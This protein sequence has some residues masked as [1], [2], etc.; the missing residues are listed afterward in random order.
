MKSLRAAMGE[1]TANPQ[2][3]QN[4]EEELREFGIIDGGFQLPKDSPRPER[5]REAFLPAVSLPLPQ[6]NDAEKGILSSILQ[7]PQWSMI[8]VERRI[9]SEHF[10]LPNHQ[11]IFKVL[12]EMH[13]ADE[14]IDLITLTNQ[15]DKQGILDA[16]GGAAY[17]TEL[18]T[19]VPTATNIDYYV[20]IVREKYALRQVI[21]LCS[22][23]Q[24]EAYSP[25]SN[26]L[27]TISY[28]SEEVERVATIISEGREET[29]EHT[30]LHLAALD[31]QNDP[32]AVLGRRWVCRG[33][34]CLWVGQAG[35]GKSSLAM[36]ASLM[37]AQAKSLWGIKNE[38]GKRLKSLF[39]QAENDAGDMA[40]ML[41]GVFAMCEPPEGVSREDFLADLQKYM[42]FH[43]DATHSGQAFARSTA[44]LIAK[45]QPDLVWIDPLLSYV[46]DDISKQ[47][48]A[49]HFLRNTMN[50]IAL[51]TG[52]VWMMLHHTGKPSNDPKSRSNW[53][54]HD[55]SYAA[56]GSSELVNWARAVNVL[57]SLG[58]N[59][60]ELRFAKRGKRAGLLEY[61]AFD[62][63]ED[64]N[65]TRPDFTDIAYL[66]H[67]QRGIFWEQTSIPD[68]V[69]DKQDR[70]KNSGQFQKKDHFNEDVLLSLLAKK[71][72][73]RKTVELSQIAT[74]ETGVSRATFYRVWK[75]L[76]ASGRVIEKQD[77]WHPVETK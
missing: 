41:Q 23:M 9:G 22:K 50:P 73:G 54:D 40:E 27:D 76:Q 10:H 46:G 21:S 6:S 59:Q 65:Y 13:G 48:V 18:Y 66:Q 47:S 52:V 75:T 33:G 20:K 2:S 42:V 67:S 69:L 53:T 64:A 61:R 55:F 71:P 34:S 56:F 68:S 37:W 24:E 28:A 5:G 44:R 49:S 16:V 1:A 30:L 74:G 26:P 58:D 31:T 19:F 62:E 3:T 17:V 29:E 25:G 72:G 38:A 35:I 14:P 39:I 7:S 51:D 32:N 43:R 11:T 4:T 70:T 63:T 77:R 60:F 57:R 45:H 15:L 36:Q 8:R 12:K